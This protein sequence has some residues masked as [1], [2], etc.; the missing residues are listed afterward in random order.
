MAYCANCGTAVKDGAAYC[1]NCGAKIAGADTCKNE[2]GTET[3]NTRTFAVLAVIVPILFFLPLIADRR[4][5]FGNFWANQSLLLL[6]CFALSSAFSFIFIGFILGAITFVLWIIAI[7]S[8]CRG[9]MK[10]IPLIG[11][12]SIIK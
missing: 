11:S 10:P 5:A 12:I 4:T 6:L 8:V 2:Q 3:D 9:E 1:S 7:V